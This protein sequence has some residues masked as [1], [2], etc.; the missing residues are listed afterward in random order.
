MRMHA[1]AL[2]LAAVGVGPA[3]ADDK[4][5]P[6]PTLPSAQAPLASTAPPQ[7]VTLQVVPQPQSPAPPP[8]PQTVTLNVQA[9]PAPPPQT[10]TLQ[11]VPQATAAAPVQVAA[12][13]AVLPA[14]VHYPG[15]LRT[16]VGNFGELLARQKMA[17]VYV[18][19]AQADVQ[20]TQAA[21]RVQ[22]APVQV[23]AQPQVQAETM[24]V[25]ATPQAP[26]K[27]R[28]FGFGR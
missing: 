21:A 17:R 13:P 25:L 15:A 26:A 24:P 19:V 18:P 20:V 22:L 9:A 14:R 11:V 23:Q 1:F 16:A 27:H 5:P 8:A 3:T 12:A 4:A 7:T 2:L 10:V 28:L 6:P